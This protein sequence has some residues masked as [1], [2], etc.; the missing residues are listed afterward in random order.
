MDWS[1][2]LGSAQEAPLD[3]ENKAKEEEVLIKS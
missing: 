3:K 1:N 2:E